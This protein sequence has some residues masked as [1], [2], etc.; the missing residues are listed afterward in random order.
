MHIYWFLDILT[1]IV[2][3]LIPS[4]QLPPNCVEFLKTW[5]SMLPTHF[6]QFQEMFKWF[7]PSFQWEYGIYTIHFCIQILKFYSFLE[8]IDREV[9]TVTFK[10]FSNILCV[11]SIYSFKSYS[12]FILPISLLSCI[13][14][15]S[16][17]KWNISGQLL[18][19][20]IL[21]LGLSK[22]STVFILLFLVKKTVSVFQV[23][24]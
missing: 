22:K 5:Q 1:Y 23:I 17:P 8:T 19:N 13:C 21:S 24:M 18:K 20:L 6:I 16:V 4:S 7:T 15:F 2:C 9:E 11:I 12:K 14:L 3:K 10:P